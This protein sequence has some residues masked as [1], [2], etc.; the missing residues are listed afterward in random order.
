MHLIIFL[1]KRFN[2]QLDI[3]NELYLIQ[4][5]NR[6]IDKRETILKIMEMNLIKQLNPLMITREDNHTDKSCWQIES[7][8]LIRKLY[9]TLCIED[10]IGHRDY[11]A[12]GAN[13]EF[14]SLNTWPVPVLWLIYDRDFNVP[15]KVVRSIIT[16]AAVSKRN[17]TG[18][19][20]EF[21]RTFWWLP[22]NTYNLFS[23]V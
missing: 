20:R 1:I 3:D 18:S 13:Y 16:L 21:C 7:L 11:I 6:S 22:H 2:Y 23:S 14:C 15:R 12:E 4:K 9:R 19:P 5:K 8:E 10:S 17:F